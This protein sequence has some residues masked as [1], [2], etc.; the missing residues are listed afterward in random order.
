MACS[1]VEVGKMDMKRSK[2]YASDIGDTGRSWAIV[3][4]DNYILMGLAWGLDQ[5]EARY[6]ARRVSVRRWRG[7]NDEEQFEAQVEEAT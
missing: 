5:E 6:I 1:S 4:T 7:D 2:L 3:T